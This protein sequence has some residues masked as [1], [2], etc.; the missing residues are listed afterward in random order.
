MTTTRIN[1]DEFNAL[2][3]S[4]DYADK[5]RAVAILKEREGDTEL[6]DTM[7]L[8][9]AQLDF[10]DRAGDTTEIEK[11]RAR[12]AELIKER[13]HATEFSYHGYMTDEDVLACSSGEVTS[14]HGVDDVHCKF[15]KGSV[16][17]PSIFGGDGMIPADSEDKK[18][19][20]A[21]ARRKMASIGHISLPMYC[22]DESDAFQIGMLLNIPSGRV[23]EILRGNLCLDTRNGDLISMK[24]RDERIREDASLR[25]S[26][27]SNGDAIHQMLID[28]NLPDHPERH[29]F[30]VL[31]VL[32][33]ATRLCV[34]D[35]KTFQI[36]E[37]PIDV[38]Y[39]RIISSS[40]RVRKLAELGAP[41]VIM[42]AE[43]RELQE[44]VNDLF[45]GYENENRSFDGLRKLYVNAVKNRALYF[46]R[47]ALL[48]AMRHTLI[49]SDIP[50][51]RKT[52][53]TVSPKALDAE[54]ELLGENQ[55]IP[56]LDVL[57]SLE[58]AMQEC[59]DRMY[60]LQHCRGDDF[61]VDNEDPDA[62]EYKHYE[63][64]CDEYDRRISEVQHA[65]AEGNPIVITKDKDGEYCLAK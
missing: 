23:V 5:L 51:I 32:N 50:V 30:K 26:F 34:M 12:L 52:V 14:S 15:V 64:L 16:C 7:R 57:D 42:Y 47:E 35:P 65:A 3:S 27:L 39:G 11:T 33:L 19:L 36:K 21:E 10:A 31:P 37:S 40:N 1:I 9:S 22:V 17:D 58:D 63:K 53:E 13:R 49:G 18:A 62:I 24:E 41:D 46:Y 25:G 56:L 61:M 8:L 54:A 6:A 29:A 20:M 60:D 38:L 59:S 43:R 55:R 45:N 44:K 28:L 4:Q 48:T 2:R